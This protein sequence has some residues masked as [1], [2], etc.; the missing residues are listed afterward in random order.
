M[1]APRVLLLRAPP[2]S[3]GIKQQSGRRQALGKSPD[4]PRLRECWGG[5]HR[6]SSCTSGRLR[7]RHGAFG[8]SDA[9]SA[10]IASAAP[11]E[12][13]PSRTSP[14]PPL[15]E[16]DRAVAH[17]CAL[18]TVTRSGAADQG[19]RRRK[20]DPGLPSRS[21]IMHVSPLRLEL[22]GEPVGV[23]GRP[24]R[25]SRPAQT[26]KGA[27]GA[28]QMQPCSSKDCSIAA[29]AMRAGPIP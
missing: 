10:A 25:R 20:R 1:R 14:L 2:R 15:A 7:V 17:G 4:R 19:R 29:A 28:G 3:G 13:G 21:S 12:R 8:I 5:A 26:S 9:C 24:R 16:I 27:I 6:L 11:R 23:L 22:G 18:P